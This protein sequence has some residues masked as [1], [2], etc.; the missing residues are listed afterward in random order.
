ML[1]FISEGKNRRK[2][3]TENFDFC[4]LD[5]SQDINT[6]DTSLYYEGTKVRTIIDK[7]GNKVDIVRLDK[8]AT[9]TKYVKYMEIIDDFS[10]QKG[11]VALFQKVTGIFREEK[12]EII[13]RDIAPIPSKLQKIIRKYKEITGEE[14]M[15]PNV[16]SRTL[17]EGIKEKI[18]NQIKIYKNK[19]KM[20]FDTEE[21]AKEFADKH[22]VKY[23]Y[24]STIEEWYGEQIVYN[25]WVVEI[26]FYDERVQELEKLLSMLLE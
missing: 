6:F 26:P 9:F 13:E 21:K 11:Y 5:R 23:S 12:L 4:I 7:K 15:R 22:G 19:Q 17:E 16:L 2:L 8:P 24:K 14:K 20:S 25:S 1:Y 18:E 3:F 10:F